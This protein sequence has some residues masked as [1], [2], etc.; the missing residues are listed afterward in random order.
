[1]VP[2]IMERFGYDNLI[3]AFATNAAEH[4]NCRNRFAYDH[5]AAEGR[6][7]TAAWGELERAI[8]LT[9]CA[10][11]TERKTVLDVALADQLPVFFSDIAF[12]LF[13]G[14]VHFLHHD[15]LGRVVATVA[16]FFGRPADQR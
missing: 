4:C 10:R 11:W 16:S 8:T 6:R 13:P 15:R 3:D 9:S 1:M 2:L 5:S 14:A 7:T 12:A